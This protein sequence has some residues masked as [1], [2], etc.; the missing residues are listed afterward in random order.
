MGK[1]KKSKIVD[2]EIVSINPLQDDLDESIGS[3]GLGASVPV[4]LMQSIR[5]GIGRG[6]K[7][8]GRSL[9][10]GSK[11]LGENL[12]MKRLEKWVDKN[13]K[14]TLAAL[15]VPGILNVVREHKQGDYDPDISSTEGSF[16]HGGLVKSGKPKLAR[17]GWR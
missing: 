3:L 6:A 5:E 10:K 2:V 12:K 17:K 1:D 9:K 7:K 16:K 14:K 8:L 4:K 13:P 15:P 11:K